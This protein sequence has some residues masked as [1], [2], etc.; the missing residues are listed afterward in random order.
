[1]A[2][3]M[4]RSQST[5]SRELTQN[6]GLRGYRHTQANRRAKQRHAVK[7]KAIK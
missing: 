4:N 2:R 6:M 3:D 1:M 5:I 7:P